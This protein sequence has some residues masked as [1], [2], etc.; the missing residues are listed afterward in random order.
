MVDGNGGR[1]KPQGHDLTAGAGTV[2][3]GGP[4]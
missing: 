2:D 4:V 3:G 1:T